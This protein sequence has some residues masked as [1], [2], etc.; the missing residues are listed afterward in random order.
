MVEV[1]V[2]PDREKLLVEKFSKLLS[3]RQ[4]LDKALEQ[5]KSEYSKLEAEIM[6]LLDDQ[7]KKSSARFEG[8]GHVTVVKPRLFARVIAEQKDLLFNWLNKNGYN[9]LI[10]ESVH[11]GSLSSVVKELIELGQEPPP[12]CDYYLKSSLNFY[13]SK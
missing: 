10:K 1:N 5:V 13:P 12:G 3:H 4:K 8:L 9:D 2:T 7:G 6:E 11:S